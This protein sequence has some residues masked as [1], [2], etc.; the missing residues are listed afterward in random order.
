MSKPAEISGYFKRQHSFEA[1]QSLS[2]KMR[3]VHPSHIPILVERR[4]RTD[5]PVSKSRFLVQSDKRV[6]VVLA[7]IKGNLTLNQEE[8]LFFMVGDNMIQPG[9]RLASLY[10][11]L[12]DEDG[13]LY[14]T[15]SRENFF[16]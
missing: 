1:R 13:F 16:G 8:M 9:E 7:Q 5:P 12:K 14:L 4:S 6:S 3:S 2:T 15:Y 11:R 10:E